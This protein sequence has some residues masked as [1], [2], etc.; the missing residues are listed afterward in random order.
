MARGS[1]EKRKLD[2]RHLEAQAKVDDAVEQMNA[3]NQHSSLLQSLDAITKNEGHVFEQMIA[4]LSPSLFEQLSDKWYG[5]DNTNVERLMDELW[6][7]LD[8]SCQESSEGDHRRPFQ[9]ILEGFPK[10]LHAV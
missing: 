9:G 3:N 8:E 10:E 5:S 7:F 4:R 6:I 1:G 2:T